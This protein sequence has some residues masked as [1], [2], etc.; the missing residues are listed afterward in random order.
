VDVTKKHGKPATSTEG[1]LP[2]GGFVG[3]PPWTSTYQ[4]AV[5]KT[6]HWVANSLKMMDQEDGQ[7]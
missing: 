5:A 1:K 2:N 6:I 3:E 4:L 7:L